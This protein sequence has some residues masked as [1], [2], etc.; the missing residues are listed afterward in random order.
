MTYK[1]R[2]AIEALGRELRL[3]PWELENER[4]VYAA[5]GD[6]TGFKERTFS[7]LAMAATLKGDRI[8]EL[9]QDPQ[10]GDFARWIAST[11]KSILEHLKAENSYRT[12]EEAK[13]NR[14]ERDATAYAAASFIDNW[15]HS[16]ETRLILDLDEDTV[17]EIAAGS[18]HADTETG[19][20]LI[21]ALDPAGEW[22]GSMFETCHGK[23][24]AREQPA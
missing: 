16:V 15:P 23:L 24:D 5:L 2:K 12:P 14:L 17:N 18:D 11:R 3:Y 1:T 10:H 22:L 4:I 8:N 6:T 7:P 9:L 19:R 13:A 20:A 21:R